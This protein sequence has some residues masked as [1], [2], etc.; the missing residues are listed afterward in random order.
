M[1]LLGKPLVNAV[2]WWHLADTVTHR[3]D[4]RTGRRML[5][6]RLVYGIC[7]GLDRAVNLYDEKDLGERV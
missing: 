7:N 1:S 3:L 5:P 2:W 6:R 4:K